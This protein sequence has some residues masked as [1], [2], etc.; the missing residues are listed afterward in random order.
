MSRQTNDI[1]QKRPNTFVEQWMNE[2]LA[3]PQH[4]NRSAIGCQN[5]VDV[6]EQ[7]IVIFY[8][9]LSIAYWPGIII[10]VEFRFMVI[11]IAVC[12]QVYVNVCVFKLTVNVKVK[13]SIGPNLF[14]VSLMLAYSDNT[15]VSRL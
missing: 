5:K 15:D 11:R 12:N 6:V 8:V 2:C 13:G 3:T 10:L 14:P 7:S 1:G 4:E 9:T